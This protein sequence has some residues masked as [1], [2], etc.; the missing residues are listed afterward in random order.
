ME[1][2]MA[3]DE[4][5]KAQILSLIPQ[6]PPFRFIDAIVDIDDRHILATYRFRKDEFFY[7]GHFPGRPITP[8]VIL[9]ETMAQAGVV[10][11]GISL[12]L[13]K[14]IQA[15]EIQQTTTLFTYAELIDFTGS[16]NPGEKVVIQ[17][18]KI[19]FRKGS[20][21]T[22]ASISRENGETVCSGVLAGTGVKLDE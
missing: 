12:L 4:Q 18:E 5:M 8:G 11:L 21:K 2:C 1:G 9:V 10:A 3:A 7:Q 19:Y 6:Q 17:G 22:K 14:G 15:S 13:H 16:V 20:I